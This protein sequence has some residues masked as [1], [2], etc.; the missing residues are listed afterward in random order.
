MKKNS[1]RKHC[2][3]FLILSGLALTAAALLV[4]IV[5]PFFQYHKPLDGLY[6]LIEN[7]I[8]QN[9]GIAKQFEYD[10]VI[11]GSSMTVNFDTDLFHEK[12]GLN[13]VKLSYDGAYP[14]DI[15]NIIHFVE[16]SP[17]ELSTV[18]L[19]IDIFT[20]KTEPGITA[21]ELPD[22]LYDDSFLTDAP[23]L[24]NKEVI[25]QYIIRPQIEGEGTPFNEMYWSWP[26]L[27]Y[28]KDAVSDS[29]WAP[30]VFSPKLPEDSYVQNISE[31]LN[32]Y[33]LPPIESMPDT[34]FYVFFPPYS[35]L[36]WYD[37]YADGSLEA[38]LRGIRQITE[39]L[40]SY[41]NVKVFYFQDQFDYITNL[42][43]YTDYT[44]YYHDMNDYMTACFADGTCQL[45]A[46]NYN[47]ALDNMLTRL[48]TCDFE[49]Y[50]P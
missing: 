3:L 39:T 41:P 14:K 38:E 8:S 46:K 4:V 1:Y 11:L 21:Y 23:Y 33:I 2:F 47:E 50:L 10:S 29:Y 17:N 44:H 16:E 19:G 37:R 5:D 48:K 32:L 24:L 25:L 49:S 35:I 31:N 12:M 30:T 7:K 20:Y 6:Y 28:G 18:F 36:Y 43:N 27:R 26:L 42:D 15:D 40:L 13:T 34:E 22:Y 45:T 9:P